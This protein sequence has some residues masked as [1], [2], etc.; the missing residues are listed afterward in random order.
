[1]G[2]FGRK[3]LHHVC[4]SPETLDCNAKIVATLNVIL[5][6][7]RTNPSKTFPLRIRITHWRKS[8]YLSLN[9]EVKRKEWD[10]TKQRVR[11]NHPLYK[12]INAHLS[13]T[14]I[15]IQDIILDKERRQ[16]AYTASSIKA[17]FQRNP[18]DETIR[19]FGDQVLKIL[20]DSHKY[21]S[22]RVYEHTLSTLNKFSDIR[23]LTF[24]KSTMP[25][26]RSMKRTF[27]DVA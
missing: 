9:L 18:D 22:R 25:S 14:L 12:K 10:E 23:R 21:G 2:R 24:M 13:R 17:A 6:L 26:S 4:T 3:C 1:M 5:D 20:S 27:Y 7:R 8:V 19:S 15:Q 11:A 16:A